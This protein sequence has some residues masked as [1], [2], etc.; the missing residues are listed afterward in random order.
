M[1]DSKNPYTDA[2]LSV[3]SFYSSIVEESKNNR[4]PGIMRE[5]QSQHSPVVKWLDQNNIN[6]KDMQGFG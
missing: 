3:V 4:T 5:K 6:I 1:A 2:I